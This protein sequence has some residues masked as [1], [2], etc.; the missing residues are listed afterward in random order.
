MPQIHRKE[1]QAHLGER[2]KAPRNV[3]FGYQK[4]RD[5]FSVWYVSD[6]RHDDVYMVVGTGH[7]FPENMELVASSVAGDFLV[8]HLLREK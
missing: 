8:F 4:S 5:A 3:T 7:E 1:I 2:F 6:D